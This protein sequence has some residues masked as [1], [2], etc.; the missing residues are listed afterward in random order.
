M[1]VNLIRLIDKNDLITKEEDDLLLEDISE[2]LMEEDISLL[3]GVKN[4]PI[5][6]IVVETDNVF[7][8]LEKQ[9]KKLSKFIYIFTFCKNRSYSEAISLYNYLVKKKYHVLFDDDPLNSLKGIIPT[10]I[11]IA[12]VKEVTSNKTFGMFIYNE[13]NS[14]LPKFNTGKLHDSFGIS[15]I[16]IGKEELFKEYRKN[17][18]G[19]PPHLLKMKKMVKNSQALNKTLY[20]YNAIKTISEKYHLTGLSIDEKVIKKELGISI[21]LALSLLNEEGIIA[22]SGNDLAT[23][24]SC[25]LA[26]ILSSRIPF[27]VTPIRSNYEEKI[28]S[29]RCDY[30]PLNQ[31]KTY[32][33]TNPHDF[34]LEINSEINIGESSLLKIG[35]DCTRFY[36][37]SS[38][39][40]ESKDDNI[41]LYIDEVPLFSFIRDLAEKQMVLVSQD[42]SAQY[43]A[44]LNYF[45]TEK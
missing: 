16:K 39:I 8:Q 14:E 31:L 4:S 13:E 2:Q 33:I 27:V 12:R 30:P 41:S 29:L 6:V 22:V 3:E 17:K 34:D 42:I 21:N 40:K 35:S 44:L 23:L 38:E 7:A 43:T 37:L 32:E 15:V 28:L 11:D 26:Y 36:A 1:N 20:L 9:L 45:D 18:V 25:Y 19:N 10:Y 5:D 24:F